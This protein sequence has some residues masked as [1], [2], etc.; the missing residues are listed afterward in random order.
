MSQTQ[1]GEVWKYTVIKFLY[2]QGGI[3]L[4]KTREIK[5]TY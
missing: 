5:N 2:K 4:S 1:G 3:V